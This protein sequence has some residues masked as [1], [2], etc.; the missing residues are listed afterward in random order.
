MTR[1]LVLADGQLILDDEPRILLCASLFPFR[2]PREQWASRIDDVKRLGYQCVDVIIPWNFHEASPGVFD[3]SGKRDVEHF[4]ELVNAAGLLVLAR[5]G[6]YICAEYDGG[7]YPARLGTI[8]GIGLR[9]NE[10]RHLA[11]VERWFGKILPILARHQLSEGGPVAMVQLE[12]ELDFSACDD[13]AGYIAALKAMA[14]RHGIAVPTIT[15]SGQ[16]DITRSNGDV[17]GVAAAVNIY[18][19]DDGVVVE[20]ITAHYADLLR[21][22][23]LPLVITE[24]NRLHRT[25]RR[26]ILAGARFVGP[27]LQASSW[28]YD[29]STST[30]SW[31]EPYAFMSS[32]YDFGG[33]IAPDGSERP[34]APEAR[35]LSAV[36]RAFG[37]RLASGIPARSA[38]VESAR[39]GETIVA[40]A[41]DLAGGGRLVGITN[42]A[43]TADVV[44]VDHDGGQSPVE[45][46]AGRCLF[47]VTDLPLADLGFPGTIVL[48]TAELVELDQDDQG[49]LLTVHTAD[50]ATV[51]V[52]AEI[53][54]VNAGAHS[55]SVDEGLVT[56]VGGAGESQLFTVTGERL[57]LR[58][59]ATAD[60]ARATVPP[61]PVRSDLEVAVTSVRASSDPQRWADWP[62][63]S[64]AKDAPL[65][66][67]H[68]GINRGSGIYRGTVPASLAIGALLGEA[69]DII[70]VFVP[71]VT[72]RMTVN[73]GQDL[74]VAFDE[75]VALEVDSPMSVKVDVWG[76]S[77]FHD[78][79]LPAMGLGSLRGISSAGL[80]TSIEDLTYGW[81]LASPA[82]SI[83][84]GEPKP[85]SSWG[86]WSS[87]ERP[88]HITYERT[89][90]RGTNELVALRIEGTQ[91]V[92][93]VE[94]DG[95][96]VG[97]VSS[98][99]PVIDLSPHIGVDSDVMLRVHARRAFD[100]KFGTAQLLRGHLAQGW[101][102]G[103]VSVNDLVDRANDDLARSTPAS[104]P[105]LVRAGEG[106]WVHLDL[107]DP[108]LAILTAQDTLARFDGV[109]VRLTVVHHGHVVARIWSEQP[110]GAQVRGGR[111]DIAMVSH[112]WIADSPTLSVLVEAANGHDGR[113]D[114]VRFSHQID[115]ISG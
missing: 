2:L 83:I 109:G 63:Q 49:A 3:F 69:S 15:C 79:R 59:V 88:Q 36:L 29:L 92:H 39:L 19:D 62:S 98:L 27:Y 96:V 57:R 10:P 80:V 102:L 31:G 20:D 11:E 21:S 67:E 87:S 52:R 33:A 40:R 60:V 91:A 14:D 17:P 78:E 45:V 101:T 55:A 108:A 99:W 9:Q 28:N 65:H 42:L 46:A 111:G 7:G 61:R 110:T 5:P 113:L 53:E 51:L 97:R 70:T 37:T 100:E 94:V 76:H 74:F 13:P 30:N 71:G 41:L 93:D 44:F 106:Q 115:R 73:A 16:G 107:E 82:G 75:P 103:E 12:N 84:V 22:R 38:G 72:P 23:G 54:A 34:D 18:P 90:R 58:V 85:Y 48:S 114:A 66:L 4:F 56:V 24:S 25:I 43:K 95:V 35:I 6:P 86:G 89:V 47:A 77:N 81:S 68:H 104:L 64:I 50:T 32:D 26:M 112:E 105:L 8:D 1:S